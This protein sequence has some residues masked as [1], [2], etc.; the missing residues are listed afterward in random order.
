MIRTILNEKGG[1]AKTTTAIQ[2]AA[3]FA[4]AGKRTLLIDGDPQGCAT[5]IL[6]SGETLI[7][8]LESDKT[9]SMV[10][11]HPESIAECIRDSGIENLYVIPG[12]GELNRTLNQMQLNPMM[13]YPGRLRKALAFIY[14]ECYDEVIIDNNPFFT[15][16]SMNSV[17]CADEVII[18]SDIE[19]G[20]IAAIRAT[21]SDV[22]D[23][24]D[25]MDDAKP[26]SV[27][28]LLTMIDRLKIDRDMIGQIRNSYKE[29]VYMTTIRTQSKPVK[30]ASFSHKIL[31]NDEKSGVAEDYRSFIEEVIGGKE[32]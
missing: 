19:Y 9:I 27:R 14:P 1:V 8:V 11:K 29:N 26:V 17:A 23:V 3:G 6:F 22:A 20:A 15:L 21:I 7:S 18:P 10:L 25:A 31:I 28:I 4:K 13:A 30:T 2:L 24:I 5:K 12:G 32:E 16:F